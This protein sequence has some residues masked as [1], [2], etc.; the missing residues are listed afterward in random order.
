MLTLSSHVNVGGISA[1]AGGEVARLAQRL[2][3][4]APISSSPHDVK[5][6]STRR[7]VWTVD[8][9]FSRPKP[10]RS[11]RGRARF[12]R[13]NEIDHLALTKRFCPRRFSTR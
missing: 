10:E 9:T 8:R 12:N 1:L 11:A 13:Y 7:S 2:P 3:R 4:Q 6:T 5:C